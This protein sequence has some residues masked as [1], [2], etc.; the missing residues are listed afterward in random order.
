VTVKTDAVNTISVP[1]QCLDTFPGL[2]I[3]QFYRLITR[4]A[5]KDTLPVKTD[6]P[7]P[8]AMPIKPPDAIIYKNN[9]IYFLIVRGY[10]GA[11]PANATTLTPGH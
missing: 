6:A 4:P 11:K 8:I 1:I 10:K 9:F 7:N 2:D 3:P 5:C